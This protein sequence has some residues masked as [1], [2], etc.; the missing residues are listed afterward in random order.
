MSKTRTLKHDGPW[1]TAGK[2]LILIV[3]L[4]FLLFPIYWV[5]VTSF[6]TNMEA[7]QYPPTF[8]PHSPVL[9]SFIKLFTQHNQF[10]VYYQ[11]N[12][13]VSASVALLGCILAIFAGY[14][15]ARFKNRWNQA[16]FALL[17]ASQMFPVISRMI[18]LYAIMGKLGI[19]NTLGG[20]IF[21]LLAAQ[22]PF[23]IILMASFFANIP[24]E[25]EEAAFVDGAGRWRILFTI[26]T[27]LVKSGLLAV[28]IYAFLM[29][30]DD[31]L[32]AA[33]LIQDDSLRTLSV[34]IALRYLGELSYDWSLVNA[35]SI[36]GTIPVVLL[37]F[38]FQK[39]MIK[40]L[41]AGAV[42]G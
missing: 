41:V 35:I 22:V 39:Y 36:I 11:N 9:D 18:S 24:T 29:T 17:L 40:G 20:L 5:L 23:C 14:S 16:F 27:P 6:K 38:F 1:Y 30:W 15:L 32:H 3:I 31:Y 13:I 10:F 4:L 25:I 7:Y 2:Y 19:I 33:T 26:V 12:L 28:G 34:G 37:F 8:F 21:A 42:K